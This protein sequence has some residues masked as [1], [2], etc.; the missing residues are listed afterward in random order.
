MAISYEASSVTL[1]MSLSVLLNGTE[2]VWPSLA[3]GIQSSRCLCSAV[4]P[5]FLP[6]LGSAPFLLGADIA[7]VKLV[8]T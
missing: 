4:A 2:S 7:T 6:I 8:V 5:S 3:P 1:L